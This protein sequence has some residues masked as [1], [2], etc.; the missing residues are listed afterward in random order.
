MVH[1]TPPFY[2]QQ[3]ERC[4]LE[5]APCLWPIIRIVWT[6]GENGQKS[7]KLF[8]SRNDIPAIIMTMTLHLVLSSF[9]LQETG[10]TVDM[11]SIRR[12]LS[13][14]VHE[15][16]SEERNNNNTNT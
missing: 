5:I 4:R 16:F 11:T 12:S 6:I 9:M 7:L 10:M 14:T 15:F 2:L 13:K 8:I 3:E 1:G